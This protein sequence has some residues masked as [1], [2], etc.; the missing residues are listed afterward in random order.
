MLPEA[1]KR[2]IDAVCAS[3]YQTAPPGPQVPPPDACAALLEDAVRPVKSIAGDTY[4][5]GGGYFLYDSCGRDLLALDA[6]TH[7]PNRAATPQRPTA[8]VANAAFERW[9]EQPGPA[10]SARLRDA[11]P[12]SAG[13]YACGQENAAATW[14][15]LPT[16]QEALHVRL[17]GKSSFSFSTSLHYSFTEWSLLEAYKSNLTQHLRI[18][19]FSGDADPCVP[20]VGTERWIE[21]LQMPVSAQWRP[22]S[23]PSTMPVSGY[24]TVYDTPGGGFTF[25]TMRDAGHMVPR[26]KPKE[27]R[28]M[29]SRWLKGEKL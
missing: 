17:V 24:V 23:A 7:A 21:S 28:Y 22:W 20:Y 11:Y 27:A 8:A 18:M 19:Q 6:E 12:N 25:A 26:Y 15:N 10:G 1:K 29:I 4:Q 16:V 5:M 13:E 2:E 3:W 14:L 9:V